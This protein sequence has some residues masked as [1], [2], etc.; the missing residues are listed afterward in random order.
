MIRSLKA[1]FEETGRGVVALSPIEAYRDFL[2]VP[3]S[4]CIYRQLYFG[5][6]IDAL[7]RPLDNFHGK[8]GTG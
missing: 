4:A 1:K 6:E 2:R 3:V 5:T 8:L 7:I